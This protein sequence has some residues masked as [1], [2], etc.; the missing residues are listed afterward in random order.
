MHCKCGVFWCKSAQAVEN[1]GGEIVRY[2]GLP[3][4]RARRWCGAATTAQDSRACLLVIKIIGWISD[5]GSEW[6]RTCARA[7]W[8][9]LVILLQVRR[10]ENFLGS[11]L[12][13]GHKPAKE[14]CRRK[15]A[16][17]LGT[18][19][20]RDI[21]GPDACKGITEASRNCDRWIGE[22]GGCREPVGCRD[23]GTYSKRNCIR[24]K[25]GASPNY[26]KQSKGC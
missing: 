19:E 20:P 4:R 10:E 14:Q 11:H 5:I 13:I 2:G 25:P 12:Q 3:Y 18:Y 7:G 1:T 6:V 8:H 22:R 26:G 24:T 15:A 16:Q 9:R 17:E 23:V 21:A